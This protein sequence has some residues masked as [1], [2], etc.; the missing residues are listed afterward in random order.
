MPCA[1]LRSLV[2]LSAPNNALTSLPAELS[3]VKGLRVLDVSGNQISMLHDSL[4][5]LTRLQSLRIGRN[6][7]ET[8]PVGLASLPNLSDLATR[9]N[10]VAEGIDQPNARN[11]TEVRLGWLFPLLP[12]QCMLRLPPL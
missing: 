1:G 10:P 7:L 12:M 2:G 9:G 5:Q 8:I 6:A 4:S 3:H 11:R